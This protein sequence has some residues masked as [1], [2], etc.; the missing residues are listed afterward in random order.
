MAEFPF[1]FFGARAGDWYEG[2]NM[3]HAYELVFAA[4]PS[5]QDKAAVAEA[6]EKALEGGVVEPSDARH[7]WLWSGPFALLR[8]G[9]TFARDSTPMREKFFATMESALKAIHAV[10][11]LRQA[12]YN[13][14]SELGKRDR[15]TAWS[16]RRQPGGPGP[17]PPN[18]RYQRLYFDDV[19]DAGAPPMAPDPAFD[20]RRLAVRNGLA[21]AKMASRGA[22]AAAAG[23]ITLVPT[24]YKKKDP[25]A[26]L[27]ALLARQPEPRVLEAAGGRYI[28]TTFGKDRSVVFH[29]AP[30]F[31]QLHDFGLPREGFHAIDLHP[32]GT[33]GIAA[34]KLTGAIY[35]LSV[36]EGTTRLVWQNDPKIDSAACVAGDG[37]A[38]LGLATKSKT[39]RDRSLHLIVPKG[40]AYER[41]AETRLRAL[42]LV[43]GLEGRILCAV[44]AE[45]LSIF[46]LRETKLKQLA[47]L[48]EDVGVVRDGG[49][50]LAVQRQ[51]SYFEIANLEGAYAKAFPPGKRGK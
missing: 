24:E 45:D 15:W 18:D 51:T 22:K 31:D 32:D 12:T 21:D 8:V 11:P 28:G 2:A 39:A 41:V 25:P 43:S 47:R 30:G 19:V 20:E 44:R 34:S 17:R 1:L 38:F 14:M 42:S 9:E 27:A 10:C 36:L 23:E 37:I 50:L 26:P 40:K 46:G 5:A 7:P 4:A 6:F 48:E 49:R 13:N 35:E 3:G 33:R 29:W 16:L